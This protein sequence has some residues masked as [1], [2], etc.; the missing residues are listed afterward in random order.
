MGVD[1][2]TRQHLEKMMADAD[3]IFGRGVLQLVGRAQHE[4]VPVIPTGSIQLDNALGIGGVPMG[5]VT[6][7]FGPESSGKT[8]LAL[9]LIAEAQ[10][11]GGAAA[12]ID[13]EHA[14]DPGYAA[15][16]GVNLDELV[17]S[18]PD[19][20]E[21]ALELASHMMASSALR[22]IVV[23][24]VAALVPKAE[25]E[26]DMGD[27]FVGAHARLMSQAMRKLNGSASK[28]QTAL[29]FINQ[30]REKIGVMFG[31]PETTTGGRAL[32]F[33]SSIRLEVRRGAVIKSGDELRGHRTKIKVVKNKMAAPFREVEVDIIFGQGIAHESDLIEMGEKLGV[34]EKAGSWYSFNSQR[35]GQGRE[36]AI[37]ALRSN[38]D[39]RQLLNATLREKLGEQ[40]Q[41]AARKGPSSNQQQ[42]AAAVAQG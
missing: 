23:D 39:L 5:R 35:L 26:G 25:L 8:T 37:E 12:F 18:Q 4:A 29:I 16:L 28:T 40:K 19:H 31:S 10:K 2:K 38:S 3:R 34:V 14:L 9:H 36:S 13:V 30:I 22:V 24:S 6:E 33:F 11:A 17:V 41:D 7:I 20:G 1:A 21:Q 15:A 42:A 32:K 27:N